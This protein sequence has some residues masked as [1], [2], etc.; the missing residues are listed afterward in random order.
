MTDC[1]DDTVVLITIHAFS[2]SILKV[3]NKV[4]KL[5]SEMIFV[6][7]FIHCDPHPGNILIRKNGRGSVEIVMLDHGL[8]Q[9]SGH[10]VKTGWIR[11]TKL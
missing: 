6:Q 11:L 4:G 3:S 7:G 2:L 8:Y 10:E 1:F 9:V 5:Y